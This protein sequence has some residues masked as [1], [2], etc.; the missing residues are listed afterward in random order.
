MRYQSE[1]FDHLQYLYQTTAFN[2]HQLHCVILFENKVDEKVMQIAVKRL[3]ETLPIL[4]RSYHNHNGRSYWQDTNINRLH[5]YFEVVDNQEAFD[6]HTCSRI[7]E[8]MG[9]Q[10]KVCLL[11]SD[12]D[13]LS[14]LM[15]H[16]VTDGA[17]L[18]L[19]VYLLSELYSKLL[20]NPGYKPNYII[21]GNRGFQDIVA[22]ITWKERIRILYLN[23][24]DSNKAGNIQFPFDTDKRAAPFILTRE[25]SEEQYCYLYDYSKT[26]G[27]TLNDML[28]TAYFRVL[29]KL[30]KQEG[31]PIDIPI[32]VDMRR[33]LEDN[34]FQ[35]LTNLSSMVTIR[36]RVD[37]NESFDR[38]LRKV[39][40]IMKEKKKNY[41]GL[42][43]FLKLDTLYK[44][45][46][47]SLGYAILKGSLKNSYI[48]MSNIGV[49]E[50]QRL[51]FDG[52]LVTS[53]Y[54]CGSIKYRPYFQLAITGFHNKI[55]LCVNSYGSKEDKNRLKNFLQLIDQELML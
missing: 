15:N 46:K 27:V 37:Q 24:K 34:G 49:L 5:S 33:Y 16:M 21:D 35:A 45:C 23:Q 32:M 3:I 7:G 50:H 51:Q 13:A 43:T 6:A 20:E 25:L 53:A 22:G 31:K 38:T 48:T 18:K 12:R 28:L 8:E 11:S 14:V 30:L 42:N 40:R 1:I 36:T 39:N 17:G 19:C 10:I 26:H 52:S 54:I 44:I 2:D 4:S 9:P 55:T 47:S 29:S 41:L